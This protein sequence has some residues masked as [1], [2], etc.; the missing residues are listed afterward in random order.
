MSN[1]GL[2]YG[3]LFMPHFFIIFLLTTVN[4]NVP[5][6]GTHIAK[7]KSSSTKNGL[8]EKYPQNEVHLFVKI[9]SVC[10]QS[11]WVTVL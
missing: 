9:A 3:D 5:V 10:R 1:D 2:Q 4:N 11:I 8:S 6:K 7:K